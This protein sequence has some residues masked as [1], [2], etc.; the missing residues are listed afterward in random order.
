MTEEI[1]ILIGIPF[2]MK[3]EHKVS[4]KTVRL[5]P[6]TTIEIKPTIIVRSGTTQALIM[7]TVEQNDPW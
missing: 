5:R 2:S 4:S 3:M 7:A 6:V 1:K